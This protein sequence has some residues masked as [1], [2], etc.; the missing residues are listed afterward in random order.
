MTK[1]MGNVNVNLDSKAS[2]VKKLTLKEDAKKMVV[3]KIKVNAMTLLKN[4]IA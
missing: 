4:V 1:K 2:N 3:S